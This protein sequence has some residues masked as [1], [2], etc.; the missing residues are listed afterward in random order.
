MIGIDGNQSYLQMNTQHIMA[1]LSVFIKKK[2]RKSS[3]CERERERE[4]Q[5]GK[6]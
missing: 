5:Q 3:V 6:K 1:C 4:I 2:E